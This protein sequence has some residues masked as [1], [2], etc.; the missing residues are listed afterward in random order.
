MSRRA[1]IGT[2]GML[3]AALLAVPAESQFTRVSV[4]LNFGLWDGVGIGFYG[5]SWDGPWNACSTPS[6]WPKYGTVSATRYLLPPCGLPYQWQASPNRL[7]E[8][9]IGCLR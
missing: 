2:T 9:C 7:V 4:G 5:S 6:K 1:T 3:A 8:L